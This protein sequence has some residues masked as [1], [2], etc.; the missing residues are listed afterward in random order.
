[1]HILPR[2]NQQQS[3]EQAVNMAAAAAKVAIFLRE[4]RFELVLSFLYQIFVWELSFEE[5]WSFLYHFLFESWALKKFY[6]LVISFYLKIELWMGFTFTAKSAKELNNDGIARVMCRPV[7]SL[8]WGTD[9]EWWSSKV[10]KA[11]SV[12]APWKL[13]QGDFYGLVAEMSRWKMVLKGVDKGFIH[14][15]QPERVPLA[16]YRP[17]RATNSCRQKVNRIYFANEQ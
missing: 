15:N 3:H 6:Q 14:P 10:G 7:S 8:V 11:Q 9:K 4:L 1:M 17:A 16:I 12:P 2:E 5:V 13:R